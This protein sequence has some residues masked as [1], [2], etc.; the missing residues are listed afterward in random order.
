VQA[1]GSQ[2]ARP[3]ALF[4][5]AE[6]GNLPTRIM[7]PTQD[8]PEQ[9]VAAPEGGL[10]A[11]ACALRLAAQTVDAGSRAPEAVRARR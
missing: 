3:A 8:V 4:G 1:W 7:N 6:P 2:R 5:L 11:V 10:A 9:R